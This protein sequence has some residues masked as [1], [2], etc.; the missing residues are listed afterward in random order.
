MIRN[1]Q[2]KKGKEVMLLM[3]LQGEE[4]IWVMLLKKLMTWR[5]LKRVRLICNARSIG[6]RILFCATFS[7]A[8]Q[9]LSPS[10]SSSVWSWQLSVGHEEQPPFCSLQFFHLS[11]KKYKTQARSSYFIVTAVMMK[12]T[13][14]VEGVVIR[15][16][17]KPPGFY[18]RGSENTI[19]C[20]K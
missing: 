14:L 19:P 8:P 16:S 4:K 6:L 3:C 15:K 2:A 18:D 9:S 5:K 12:G 7:L 17:S 11:Q 20:R 1:H 10:P 13:Q